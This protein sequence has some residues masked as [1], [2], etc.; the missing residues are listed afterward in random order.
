MGPRK[1]GKG[2]YVR[3]RG[4]GRISTLHLLHLG[5]IISKRFFLGEFWR[6]RKR[7]ARFSLASFL[8]VERTS[9]LPLVRIKFAIDVTA[10]GCAQIFQ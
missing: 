2:C 1:K 9:I 10:V 7:V 8:K 5:V 6:N 3:D 4:T